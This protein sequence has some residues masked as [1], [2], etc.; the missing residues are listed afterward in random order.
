MGRRRTTP[1]LQKLKT[2]DDSPELTD[3]KAT[4]SQK[5]NTYKCNRLSK[6]KDSP[7]IVT[8]ARKRHALNVGLIH[9][10]E[11][12]HTPMAIEDRLQKDSNV[13]PP[14]IFYSKRCQRLAKSA[15]M[16]E[17]SEQN[18]I[19]AVKRSRNTATEN[20]KSKIISNKFLEPNSDMNDFPVI[21][22]KKSYSKAKQQSCTNKK[23]IENK[24]SASRV[25]PEP[26]TSL[27]KQNRVRE[28]RMKNKVHMTTEEVITELTNDP[29]KCILSPTTEKVDVTEK[30]NV[31]VNNN[32]DNSIAVKRF[33][34]VKLANHPG[35]KKR[36]VH[37]SLADIVNEISHE[38][39]EKKHLE[40]KS[41]FDSINS[42]V[43]LQN[44]GPTTKQ[45]A[46]KKNH[47]KKVSQT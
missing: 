25:P 27:K 43:S 18:Y 8:R 46:I 5:I 20:K 35:N 19:P 47:L 4:S 10:L 13:L 41:I 21:L 39:P 31:R 1:E 17:N 22:Q 24:I 42:T 30:I 33:K 11:M 40:Y 34:T 38:S 6:S 3:A 14:K 7:Q 28:A 29:V 16:P 12:N 2:L 9:V 15:K 23:N 45:K 37:L 26:L 44:G 36:K 32:A